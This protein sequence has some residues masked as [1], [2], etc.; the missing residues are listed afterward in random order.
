MTAQGLLVLMIV[1]L[2]N[3]KKSPKMKF[4]DNVD[5]LSRIKVWQHHKTLFIYSMINI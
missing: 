1:F 2:S 5:V 4:F 3:W